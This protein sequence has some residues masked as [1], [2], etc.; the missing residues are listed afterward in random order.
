M[1]LLIFPKHCVGN[2]HHDKFLARRVNWGWLDW[3]DEINHF[4]Y[5]LY[6]DVIAGPESFMEGEGKHLLIL[7]SLMEG[8]FFSEMLELQCTC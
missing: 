8:I 5:D 7:S 4:S 2:V 3:G 6:Y 1:C